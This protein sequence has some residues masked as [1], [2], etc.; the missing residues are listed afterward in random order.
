MGGGGVALHRI[1]SFP[2]NIDF[3]K[4]TFDSK[5]NYSE[6]FAH[7]STTKIYIWN[8]TGASLNY[9]LEVTYIQYTFI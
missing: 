4:N 5:K 9:T 7:E 1:V 3:R 2:Q 6:T 8:Y